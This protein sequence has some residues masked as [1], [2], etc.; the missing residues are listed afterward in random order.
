[1]MLFRRIAYLTFVLYIA[2]CVHAQTA[3]DA[4]GGIAHGIVKSGNAPIPGATITAANTLTGQKV[5]TSSDVDGSFIL[6]L[7]SNGRYVVKAQMP[8]FASATREIV[9]NAATRDA[10]VDL[11]LVLASRSQQ[12]SASGDNMAARMSGGGFQNLS[13]M[14]NQN[15]G[16]NSGNGSFDQS[17]ASNMPFP[18]IS[19][20]IAT[21]SVAVSGNNSGPGLFGMSSDEMR[22]R[23]QEAREA[24]SGGPGGGGPGG[25]GGGPGGQG[26]PGGGPG[27]AGGPGG[28]P[29]MIGS[30]GGFGGGGFGGHGGGGAGPMIL[31]GGRGRFDINRP[32]GMVYY[33]IGDS[34]LNAAP[35]SLTGAPAAN[36]QYAQ[37]RYGA[38]LGGPFGIP[39]LYKGDGKTFFF[40]NFNGARADNPFDSFATV[41]TLSERSGNFSDVMV[42]NGSN[43]GLPVQI[44]N[45]AT[46]APFP[47][48]TIPAINPSA[49][50]LLKFIPEPN[51]PG[52]VQNFHFVTSDTNNSDD[53]NI[54]LM[55]SFGGAVP[56]GGGGG[57]GRGR[58]GP[59]NN[60]NFGFHYRGTE[61]ELTN[62]FPG[63]G[64]N[65]SARSF[66]VPV[67]YVRSFGKLTNIA[68]FDFNRSRLATQNLF[69]FLTD[70]AGSAGI[71]GVSVNP[72]DWGGPNVTFTN[73]SGLSDTN[74]LLR[75]NQTFTWSDF[76]ILTH[77]KHT[78][79]WGGDFRRIELNTMTDSNSRG[80]FVFTGFNTAEVVNGMAT[81]G[82]G[83][84][85]ADFLLGLPQQTSVQ[86]G[87][88][89]Y[90]F[91]GNSWDLFAQDEWRLR[92]NLTLNIGVRYEYVSPFTETNNRIV[93]LDVAPTF[94]AAV[95]VL[96]GQVGPFSGAFPASLVRPDRNNFA[97]R[98]GIAWKPFNPTVV[99][100]GYGINYN[101]GAY[102]TI[103]QQLAFQPPFSITQT[104]VESAGTPLT[105]Q[106]GFPAAPPNAI[107]NNYGVDPN[108]RLGYVQIWN[109]DIQQEINPTLVVNI[110]YTGTK[111]TRL[112][113]V[114]APNRTATGLLI[115][116]VQ[117]FLFETSDGSSI[118]HMGTLRVRKRLQHGVS[119]G[120]RYTFS[121]SIDNASTIGGGT[122]IVAQNAFDLAA[123]RGLSSYDQR[124]RFT[125]DYLIE[126]PFGHDRRWLNTP[127]VAR[128]IFGDWQW[129][130]DWTIASGMPFTARVIGNF[131]DVNRG[132]N[133]TLRADYTGLP[134][135][136]SDATVGEWFNTA[137][138]VTPPAGQFGD[139][140]RNTIIGPG[141][142][143][144]DM[145]FTKM[146]PLGDVRML[147]MRGQVSNIFNTPQFTSIDT[148]V[149]S[150]SFGRV[151]SVGSMRSI[152]LTARFRF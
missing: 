137:A 9:I 48:N 54:R 147:E 86:Y 133:G 145:A 129:S 81:P 107:T 144:F 119:M 30:S 69:A 8:A 14:E 80:T 58:R 10:R 63:I 74:P 83:Y 19:S 117:P 102:D 52:T 104:N 78:L 118:A 109:L 51:L 55:H 57:G 95:P 88:N 36:P 148:A 82:T 79:R 33:S 50:A 38:S 68:R 141:S 11:D 15:G 25:P 130:G 105:L 62:P 126:L 84:D 143:L 92:G 93:N 45:P 106:N 135:S 24:Q 76:M 113:I 125:A 128:A 121:K 26:G 138:F 60:L 96:P 39:K 131:A 122:V 20:E 98:L 5:I 116:G 127:G 94:T 29:V 64:G 40:I 101:T 124:H 142:R 140:G 47:N 32:H 53:V 150:P 17:A 87:D 49:A 110:G 71:G 65:T 120:G 22:Q 139:A 72:F 21:E 123:E 1:M 12:P 44:F 23:F 91:R 151:I 85:F 77:G 134:I 97:P 37:H 7:P 2:A 31:L 59:Q 27:G 18:G 43:A 16:Q 41:P 146:F 46:G 89:N 34:A 111:G 75:R 70:I 114:E 108:Y 35:Y 152:Q 3:S 100:A 6:Q 149:N 90:H 42:R 132:T 112:D 73:F 99:R 66:D 4:A 28:G 56:F 103:A 61:T 13:V 115:P 136:L 67:G